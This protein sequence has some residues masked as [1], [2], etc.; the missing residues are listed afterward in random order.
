MERAEGDLQKVQRNL[1]T[2]WYH[3]PDQVRE[4]VTRILKERRV[5]GLYQ[6]EVGGEPGSPTFCWERDEEAIREAE[7]LDGFYVLVTNLPADQ[8]DASAVLN[9]YKGQHRVERRFGD[10]KGPLA[11]NPVL[12]KSN[13]R[14]A[15]LIF[16]V[17]L[18]LLVFSLMERQARQGVEDP[19]GLVRGLVPDN[20]LARPT[21]W[22]LLQPFAWLPLST[23]RTEQGLV[24]YPPQLTSA[25]RL[26]HAARFA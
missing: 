22:N 20:R 5:S 19:S 21:G 7:A 8:Y 9:L 15:A 13:R 10:F 26:V 16:V 25:Q 3:T 14:I 2:R 23:V 12:L 6:F 1:G 4:R 17:Y 18:A 24:L 11:V